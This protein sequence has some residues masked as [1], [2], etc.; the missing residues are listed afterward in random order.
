MTHHSS[1]ITHYP[2]RLTSMIELHDIHKTYKVGGELVHALRGVTL[3]IEAGDYVAVTG[4]SGS[5][6]STLMHVIGLLDTPE[7]GSYRLNGR[8]VA[9]LTQDEL[10]IAR[11]KQ[12][13]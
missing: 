2:S 6:K 1:H 13:G 8:E 3:T 5:G 9:H 7:R 10:A 4:P 12:V 11:R